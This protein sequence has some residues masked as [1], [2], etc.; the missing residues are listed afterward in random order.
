MYQAKFGTVDIN[1]RCAQ[2]YLTEDDEK[3]SYTAVL[4][5]LNRRPE[6]YDPTHPV[7]KFLGATTNPQALGGFTKLPPR[8]REVA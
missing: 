4:V 2:G 1:N 6:T 3:Q 5:D 7:R 8:Q